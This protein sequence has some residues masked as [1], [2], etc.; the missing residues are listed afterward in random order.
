MLGL[1]SL[2]NVN[3]KKKKTFIYPF[4][5]IGC[6]VE[7][8]CKI[9]QYGTTFARLSVTSEQADPSSIIILVLC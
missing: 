9:F 5:F 6:F 3:L 1:L 4:A 7:F 2:C 8:T